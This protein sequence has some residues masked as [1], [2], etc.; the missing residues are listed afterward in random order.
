MGTN[1]DFQLKS[2]MSPSA[3]PGFES[4]MLNCPAH[5]DA[6]GMPVREHGQT[7]I[8]RAGLLLTDGPADQFEIRTF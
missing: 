2:R 1:S 6:D 7:E 3:L 8:T 4:E 5:G